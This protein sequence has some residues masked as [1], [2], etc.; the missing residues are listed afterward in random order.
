[1]NLPQRLELA[2]RIKL[3]E[4]YGFKEVPDNYR[5]TYAKDNRMVWESSF[6]RH[7]KAWQTADIINGKWQNHNRFADFEKALRRPTNEQQ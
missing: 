1:M 4:S 2:E 3:A 5:E 6:G 7:G